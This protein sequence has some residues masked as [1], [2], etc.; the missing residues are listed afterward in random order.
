MS[1]VLQVFKG[2]QLLACPIISWNPLMDSATVM[3]MDKKVE[4][5]LSECLPYSK[6]ACQQIAAKPQMLSL[7]Q[8]TALIKAAQQVSISNKQ[9]NQVCKAYSAMLHTVATQHGLALENISAQGQ[10]PSA[11][12]LKNP[13]LKVQGFKMR[14]E[15]ASVFKNKY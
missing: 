4:V 3:E 10:K 5:R 13:A 15:V 11:Q 8:A 9:H 2:K 1:L 6:I 7:A 14:L 12:K